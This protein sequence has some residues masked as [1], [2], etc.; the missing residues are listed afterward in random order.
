MTIFM[1]GYA[2]SVGIF[3]GDLLTSGLLPY[4][5]SVNSMIDG[6]HGCCL[7]LSVT[8]TNPTTG[9]SRLLNSLNA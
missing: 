5:L 2:S 7:A 8:S 9:I 6:D 3:S 1:P 4:I